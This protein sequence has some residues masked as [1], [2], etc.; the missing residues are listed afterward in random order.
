[1]C[2]R[3][4]IYAALFFLH[5][6]YIIRQ[7]RIIHS[8]NI[9][10]ELLK[11]PKSHYK[12]SINPFQH[13]VEQMGLYLSKMTGDPVDVCSSY[14]R[15]AIKSKSFPG[16]NDPVVEYYEREENG[17]RSKKENHLSYY[18]YESLKNNDVIAPSFTTYLHSSVR[19]SINSGFVEENKKQRSI[20]KKASHAAKALKDMTTYIIKDLEQNGFKTYN[21]AMSGAFATEGSPLHNPSAHSTLTST[22]RYVSS[23]CNASNERIISGNRIY[24][25]K[26]A[27]IYNIFSIISKTN[28]DLLSR[29]IQ[30]YQ[31]HYPTVGEA[32]SVV[33]KSSRK[34]WVQN[35][36]MMEI[37]SILEKLSPLEL[38]S[39]VYTGDLYHLRLYN[40][41]LLR[42]FMSAVITKVSSDEVAKPQDVYE[43]DETILYFAHQI[44]SKETKGKGKRYDEMAELGTLSTLVATAKHIESVLNHYSDL[45]TVVLLTDNPPPSIAFLPTMMRECVPLSDTDSSCSAA[46]EWIY[47]YRGDYVVDDESLSLA[48]AMT[49]LTSFSIAHALALFSANINMPTEKIGLLAAKNEYTWAVMVLTSVAKHY[50]ALPVVQEGSVFP[51]PELEIK[52]VHLK[53]SN[54][55]ASINKDSEALMRKILMTVYEN[56]KISIIEILTHIANKERHI[57]ASLLRGEKEFYRHSMIQKPE[58]YVLTEDESPYQ[59]YKLWCQVFEPKYGPM[60]PPPVSVI[61]IAT[62]LCNKTAIAQWLGGIEDK[63]LATNMLRWLK[64]NNK[65]ALNTLYLSSVYVGSN[66]I[67]DEIKPII[68][69]RGIALDL[70][71][72]YRIIL[73]SLGCYVKP[74]KLISDLGY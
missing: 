4:F 36:G 5:Y 16:M 13:Y 17:D 52:G 69:T 49:C 62:V 7:G 15:E 73:E 24:W 30:K 34:Y 26:E 14:I 51:E 44:C 3:V 25:T 22:T 20:A 21:N 63:E 19:E 12:R 33:E 28:F 70:T 66:G 46:Q 43:I 57:Q 11:P 35:K 10:M 53:N 6:L 67:P 48:S 61:K 59:H 2:P 47:W 56:K 64:N 18:L 37:R 39:F 38:A 29:V 32:M 54:N 50:Y 23:I 72:V 1:M 42:Q 9:P 71:K 65:T 27:V 41:E 31:L 8:F 58:S 74:T 55:P 45:L 60:E 68:D 40:S